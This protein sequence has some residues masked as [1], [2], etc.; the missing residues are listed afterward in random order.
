MTEYLSDRESAFG[1]LRNVVSDLKTRERKTLIQGVKPALQLA[2]GGEF[3]EQAL[4]FRTF[5][6]FVDAA[7]SAGYVSKTRTMSGLSIEPGPGDLPSRSR[8]PRVRPDLWRAVLD[9]SAHKTHWWDPQRRH[10]VDLD[11]TAAVPADLVRLEPLSRDT[12]KAWALD[13]LSHHES[14]SIAPGLVAALQHSEEGGF[15]QFSRLIRA[16][17]RLNGEWQGERRRR[18]ADSIR[19]WANVNGLEVDPFAPTPIF[20]ETNR[21]QVEVDRGVEDAGVRQLRE[22]VKRAVDRMSPTELRQLSLP[23]GSLE[24]SGL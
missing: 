5:R 24:G 2:S 19:A 9:W 8:L 21:S 6:E 23:V 20:D 17:A 13:F 18:V 7:E 4:G 15:E 3:N 22:A 1:A 11:S 12:H 10:V 16:D 14:S